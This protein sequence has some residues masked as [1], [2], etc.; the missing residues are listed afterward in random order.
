M[1]L[2]IALLAGVAVV[3][4]ELAILTRQ[5]RL[6]LRD[7]QRRGFFVRY[8]QRSRRSAPQLRR[9]SLAAPPRPA[10]PATPVAAATKPLPVAPV[11]SAEPGGTNEAVVYVDAQG[12]CTFANR[13]ARDLLHWSAGELALRDV[14]AGGT[15]ESDALLEALARHGLVEQHPSFLAGPAPAPLEISAVALRDRDDNLW[16]AAL[17]IRPAAG[18]SALLTPPTR[19]SQH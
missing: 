19:R 1:L 3:G 8:A 7:P 9:P 13:A 6:F 4:I 16:G 10:A 14:L 18:A 2:W 12:H 15:G 5:R 11:A 17:F